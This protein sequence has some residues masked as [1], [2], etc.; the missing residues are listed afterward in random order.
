MRNDILKLINENT[1]VCSDHHHGHKRLE[2]FEPDRMI[3]AKELGYKNYEEMQIAEHNKLVGPDDIVLFFGDFSFSSPAPHIRRYNGQKI[4]IVGNHDC[5]GDNAYEN[6][7]FDYVVRGIYF[8][9]LNNIWELPSDNKH[10]SMIIMNIK[11]TRCALTHYPIGFYEKYNSQ[12]AHQSFS[13]QDTMNFSFDIAKSL[14][15]RYVIHGHL[16][17]KK[18]TSYEF[19]YINVCLEH[20]DFKPVKLGD[21]FI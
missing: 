6:A 4:L 14:D 11:N 21:L 3:K 16:H 13:I 7:G 5:R 15:V 17:S 19:R 12:N 20:T 10:Q 9:Y 2:E 18:A 1:W 8:N